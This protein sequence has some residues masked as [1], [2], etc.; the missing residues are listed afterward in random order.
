MIALSGFHYTVMFTCIGGS[1]KTEI[2][3]QEESSNRPKHDCDA[4][5]SKNA[6]QLDFSQKENPV[7]ISKSNSSVNIIQQVFVI[8]K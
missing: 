4:I 5:V 7:F 1:N 3:H 2:N 6:D 8:G